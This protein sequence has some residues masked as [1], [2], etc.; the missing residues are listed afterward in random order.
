MENLTQIR[1]AASL[2]FLGI[3]LGA[4][5]AH[6]LEARLEETG[7]LDNWETASFYHLI[8]ALAM[9]IVALRGGKSRG[10]Y[11][12]LAGIILFSG[13]LYALAL[14]DIGRL[15]VITPLGGLSF[16]LGWGLW[17]F[18]PVISKTED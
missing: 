6:G 1:I 2:L 15:G 18:S 16:L 7:R 12:F 3:A 10:F 8:H 9:F 4:F 17:I 11:W 14:S 13:S 5:G